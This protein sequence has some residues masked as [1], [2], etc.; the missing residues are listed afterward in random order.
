MTLPAA[1]SS[2]DA[3]GNLGPGCVGPCWCSLWPNGVRHWAKQDTLG[4]AL[5]VETVRETL[6]ISS[7]GLDLLMRQKSSVL[8]DLEPRREDAEGKT[9]G[10]ASG[11]RSRGERFLDH[12]LGHRLS[13]PWMLRDLAT[14]L[15]YSILI[16]GGCGWTSVLFGLSPLM[17]VPSK[18]IHTLMLVQA[19]V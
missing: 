18:D 7:G 10:F 6:A 9:R 1:A 4:E 2:D 16:A 3:L 13:M 5:G 17:H 15:S 12:T 14:L 8:T 11:V 19:P